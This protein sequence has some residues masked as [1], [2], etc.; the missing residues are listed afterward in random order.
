[1]NISE[2]YSKGYKGEIQKGN[3]IFSNFDQNKTFFGI[4]LN[5]GVIRKN[6]NILDFGCGM[7]YFLNFLKL[8]GFFN[9]WGVDIART[10]ISYAKNNYKH[11][12]FRHFNLNEAIPFK[13]EF[14]DTI[15]S[16]DVLEHAPDINS[17]LSQMYDL[18]NHGGTYVFS[19][20]QKELDLIFN[21]FNKDHKLIHPSLQ[22]RRT[23]KQAIKKNNFSNIQFFILPS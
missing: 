11:I 20:P 14:F 12:E 22:N 18:L 16:F 5:K 19:T 6:N 23:L 3:T 1:M 15:L 4:L 2:Y 7:G 21:L 17:H 13:K 8:Q 10:A 9:L